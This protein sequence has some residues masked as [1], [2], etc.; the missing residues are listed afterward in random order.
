MIKIKIKNNKLL[1]FVIG[2]LF[3]LYVLLGSFYQSARNHFSSYFSF[4]R[5]TSFFL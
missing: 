3:H 5:K 2:L 4:Q 1:M